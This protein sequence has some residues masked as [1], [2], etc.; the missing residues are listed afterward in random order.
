MIWPFAGSSPCDDVP[1]A[2][3]ST[4][5]TVKSYVP[6]SSEHTL[7]TCPGGTVAVS[8]SFCHE[9][10]AH[11]ALGASFSAPRMALQ[12]MRFFRSAGSVKVIRTGW[13]E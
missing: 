8:V 9:N 5:A 4:G 12:R 10:S 1:C 13:V 6:C 7:A 11:G 2:A 3:A